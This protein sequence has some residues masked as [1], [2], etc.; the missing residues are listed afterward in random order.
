MDIKL[1]GDSITALKWGTT[2]RFT[3]HLCLAPALLYILV[4]IKFDFWVCEAEHVAGVDNVTHDK[5]SR[6]TPP[7]ELGFD[8][9]LELDQNLVAHTLQLCDPTRDLSSIPDLVSFWNEAEMF[10]TRL[11]PHK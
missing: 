9:E 1:I 7:S 10:I 11:A 2:E 8:A 5:L 4:G 6:G 3:G